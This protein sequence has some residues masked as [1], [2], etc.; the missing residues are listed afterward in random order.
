M[1][2]FFIRITA[3]N[4]ALVWGLSKQLHIYRT[5]T[6]YFV[7]RRAVCRY[8][9]RYT[10]LLAD[11]LLHLG[12]L[13]INNYLEFFEDLNCSNCFPLQVGGSFNIKRF[14]CPENLIGCPTESLTLSYGC[15][16][17]ILWYAMNWARNLGNPVCF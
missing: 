6:D 4:P 8:S 11:C 14:K 3:V 13:V 5:S 7:R 1:I 12:A 17:I 15:K 16:V 2:F 10:S 9:V